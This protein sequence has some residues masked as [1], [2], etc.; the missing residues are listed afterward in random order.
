MC[1]LSPCAAFNINRPPA[2]P[3]SPKWAV[4][5][6]SILGIAAWSWLLLV[7]HPIWSTPGCSQWGEC[8]H[9]VPSISIFS[10]FFLSRFNFLQNIERPSKS[11]RTTTHLFFEFSPA[12][13]FFFA[14]GRKHMEP[15]TCSASHLPHS[16]THPL[17][18]PLDVKYVR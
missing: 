13:F 2:Q 15:M 8:G 3:R 1:R 6:R 7:V 4:F 16:R 9:S 12:V 11:P 14:C 10:S 5:L 18:L 17:R